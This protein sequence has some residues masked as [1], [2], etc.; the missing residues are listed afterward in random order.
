MSDRLPG[1]RWSTPIWYGRWRIY[2]SDDAEWGREFTYAY[3]HD[4]YDGA[5]DAHDGRCGHGA[6]VEECRT[7]IDDLWGEDE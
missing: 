1:S 6:T 2:L 3:V 5:P 4:D 7:E